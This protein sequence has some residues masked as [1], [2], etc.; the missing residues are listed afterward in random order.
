M[1]G[2]LGFQQHVAREEMVA[3]AS[4]L[5]VRVGVERPTEPRSV[6]WP[7]CSGCV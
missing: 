1:P 2:H 4:F 5:E 6:F 7:T 3:T